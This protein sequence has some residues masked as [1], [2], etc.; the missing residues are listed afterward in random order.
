M[1]NDF[2]WRTEDFQKRWGWW[3]DS[4]KAMVV[5]SP[6]SEN[7]C[8][9]NTM[10]VMVLISVRR[11]WWWEI[12]D[13][14]WVKIF[15]FSSRAY[16]ALQIFSLSSRSCIANLRFSIQDPRRQSNGGTRGNKSTIRVSIRL[17]M[18]V[19]RFRG[20]RWWWRVWCVVCVGVLVSP[21]FWS[22]RRWWWFRRLVKA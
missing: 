14:G 16:I 15:N 21:E 22:R 4:R 3:I 2:G 18:R 1:C 13:I 19:Y 12:W 8:F 9:S 17:P 11:W 20:K 10:V 6:I 7:T 5:V